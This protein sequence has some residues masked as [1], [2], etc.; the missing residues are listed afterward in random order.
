M[1]LIARAKLFERPVQFWSIAVI[2][3][4]RIGWEGKAFSPI[5]ATQDQISQVVN[6]FEFMFPVRVNEP[7]PVH[8]EIKEIRKGRGKL[9]VNCRESLFIEISSDRN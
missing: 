3:L 8:A 4:V 1:L 2:Q 5:L 6:G 7:A 9:A